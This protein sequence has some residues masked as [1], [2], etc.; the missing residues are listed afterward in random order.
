MKVHL[1]CFRHIPGIGLF[2]CGMVDVRNGAHIPCANHN[3]FME[4]QRM[5]EVKTP[6]DTIESREATH[7]D[8]FAQANL[9]QSLK[10][11]IHD[12]KKFKDLP[13]DQAET[14]DMICVK[15]SRILHGNNNEPDHW[16]DLAGYATLCYNRLK[17]GDH[18]AR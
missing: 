2:A 3:K 4:M 5:A 11:M 1:P 18:L 7:G 17:T 14:L 9:A 10:E 15:I 12:A 8:Y 6:Q 13:V 16:L